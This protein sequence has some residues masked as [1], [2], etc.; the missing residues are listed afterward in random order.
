MRYRTYLIVLFNFTPSCKDEIET[1]RKPNQDKD[2][3]HRQG[4]YPA[5]ENEEEDP[6][7]DEEEGRHWPRL[8]GF[9]PRP[10]W[11]RVECLP[12]TAMM[13]LL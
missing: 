5:A 4:N 2:K 9:V 3:D 1:I 10:L 7:D 13:S 11:V 6:P 8:V 12:A